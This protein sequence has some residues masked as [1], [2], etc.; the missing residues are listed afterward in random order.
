MAIDETIPFQPV[1][2]AVLT[3]SDTR[4]AAND[5]SGDALVE[6]LTSEDPE[7]RMP[8][9]DSKKQM[10]SADE[11]ELVGDNSHQAS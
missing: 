9:V 2:I 8:P 11:I 5:T 10:L 4:D 6:R 3:V 7:F 1:R